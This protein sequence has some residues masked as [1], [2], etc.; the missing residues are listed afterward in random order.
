MLAVKMN[1]VIYQPGAD[2][3]LHSMENRIYDVVMVLHM[4][5]DD[6]IYNRSNVFWK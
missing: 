5:A 6:T 3:T 4:L 2:Q 1:I